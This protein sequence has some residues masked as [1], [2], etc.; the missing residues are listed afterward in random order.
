MLGVN[1]GCSIASRPLDD[2]A[3]APFFA[4]LNRRGTTVFLH[5][6]G[7][8]CGPFLEDFGLNFPLGAPFEDSIAAIR[9][10]LVGVIH[11]FPKIRFIVPHLGGTLPFLVRGSIT[12]RYQCGGSINP[13]NIS[14]ACGMTRSTGM[15][16]HCAAPGRPSA[17][18]GWCWAPIFPTLPANGSPVREL[19]RGV[20]S[21]TGR[22]TGYSRPQR[23]GTAW[24][25]DR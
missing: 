8:G 2:A 6:V 3:F 21:A 4:E 20:R 24:A 1:I 15:L 7:C 23:S 12:L 9:L 13:V 18:I 19:H 14:S 11:R 22:E 10:V 25:E 16:Q 5:P 17:P